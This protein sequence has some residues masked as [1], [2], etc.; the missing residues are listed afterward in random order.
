[1]DELMNFE[2]TLNVIKTER[3][4][5]LRSSYCSRDCE[6]CELVLSEKDIINAYLLVE[7]ILTQIIEKGS[8]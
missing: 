2:K 6:N 3:E 7:F 1:M 8:F 5:V 4:C